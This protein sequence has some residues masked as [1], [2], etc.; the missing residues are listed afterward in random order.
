MDRTGASAD[1]GELLR[2]AQLAQ[3]IEADFGHLLRGPAGGVV[4]Y[5]LDDEDEDE[6]TSRCIGKKRKWEAAGGS[7]EGG[8]REIDEDETRVATRA[9]GAGGPCESCGGEGRYRCPR[10]DRRSCGVAC[11]RRHKEETG[12]SGI[13]D[14]TAFVPLRGMTDSHLHS[15]IITPLADARILASS[16]FQ[17]N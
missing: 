5:E 16:L 2:A 11:V 9:R 7:G 14:R 8:E 10:C 6:P 12:C 15:G 13:R 4:D 17:S 3:A 1:G